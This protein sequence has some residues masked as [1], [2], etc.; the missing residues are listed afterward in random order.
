M[1]LWR[2]LGEVALA[3]FAQA[4][5]V[6]APAQIIFLRH[7]EKPAVGSELNAR[8]WERAPALVALFERDPRVREHGPAV[9]I[10]AMKPAKAGGSV[11]A[12]QTMAATGRALGVTL[13]R[14]LTREEIAPLV[15]A[16]MDAPAF[17]GK[18][19]VVCWEHKVLPEML[20]AFGWT[21]GPKKWDGDDYDRLW[22][23]DFE[24]GKPT[25]FRNL[26][27]KLLP[28]DAAK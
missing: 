7:A 24:H 18:T 1:T 22:L 17:E 13:D 16:I 25:R 6:A 26:P 28:G 21:S 14:H 27:Q 8:G 5:A 2:R 12:I 11:R 10:F 20:T 3:W 4:L 9:A 23:L 19:V 15:R